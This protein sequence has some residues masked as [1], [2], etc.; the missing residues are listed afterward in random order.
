MKFKLR[1]RKVLDKDKKLSWFNDQ[2]KGFMVCKDDDP[3]A[4]MFIDLK[5]EKPET[6]IPAT[7]INDSSYQD[8][9]RSDALTLLEEFTDDF[10]KDFY[11]DPSVTIKIE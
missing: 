6:E 5:D 8:T 11:G 3:I 1:V 9:D 2:G 7:M 4:A 10:V